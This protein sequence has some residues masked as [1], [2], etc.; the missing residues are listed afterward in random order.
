MSQSQL[1]PQPFS[2]RAM[3]RTRQEHLFE[4]RRLAAEIASAVATGAARTGSAPNSTNP[5]NAAAPEAA[6]PARSAPNRTPAPPDPG[7]PA[8][9]APGFTRENPS[10]EP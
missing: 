8:A 9:Y 10:Q 5:R 1:K 6:I 7:R 2:A 3:L 4:N